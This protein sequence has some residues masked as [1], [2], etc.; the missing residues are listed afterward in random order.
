MDYIPELKAEVS[1]YGDNL[2]TEL[3]PYVTL[4]GT[5]GMLDEVTTF[6]SSGGTASLTWEEIV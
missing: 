4:R 3:K 5:Y 6:T 1:A 2:I